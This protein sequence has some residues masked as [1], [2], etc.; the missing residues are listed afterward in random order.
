VF[1]ADYSSKGSSK[2]VEINDARGIGDYP[3]LPWIS[4][5]DRSP[6]GWWDIQDRRNRE[7]PVC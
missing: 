4:A 6:H 7:D 1:I 3:D 5:Q 2:V